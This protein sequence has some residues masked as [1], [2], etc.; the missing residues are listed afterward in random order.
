MRK[1]SIYGSP[2]AGLKKPKTNLF[3][4]KEKEK[5]EFLK[6]EKGKVLKVYFR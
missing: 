6:G 5:S 4:K 1:K 3:K 2:V